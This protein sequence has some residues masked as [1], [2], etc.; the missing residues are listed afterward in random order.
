MFLGR[1]YQHF[2]SNR[3]MEIDVQFVGVFT[4]RLQTYSPVTGLTLDEKYVLANISDKLGL[5]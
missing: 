1:E 5:R 2:D 3:P 4:S